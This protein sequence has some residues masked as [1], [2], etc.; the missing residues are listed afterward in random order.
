MVNWIKIGSSERDQSANSISINATNTYIAPDASCCIIK[1]IRDISN[2]L[3]AES[4]NVEILGYTSPSGEIITVGPYSSFIGSEGGGAPVGMIMPWPVAITWSASG[5]T[6]PIE[7]WLFCDGSTIEDGETITYGDASGTRNL[8]TLYLSLKGPGPSPYGLGLLPDL[9]GKTI[10]GV[11]I[12]TMTSSKL[13]GDDDFNIGKA[14]KGDDKV[15]SEMMPLHT[16]YLLAEGQGTTPWGNHSHTTVHDHPNCIGTQTT[17]N[18]YDGT[19]SGT[20]AYKGAATDGLN[21]IIKCVVQPAGD[22]EKMLGLSDDFVSTW[23]SSG[24]VASFAIP[25][26]IMNFLIKY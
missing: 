2:T 18:A 5:P 12:L 10:F 21:G 24:P 15:K 3:T 25:H 22:N 9:R 11:N 6:E 26:T 23:G 17:I 8:S 19:D 7:G 20:P 4:S 14:S 13:G 1:P 16:H